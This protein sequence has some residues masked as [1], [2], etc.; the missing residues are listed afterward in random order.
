[1]SY[2]NP[3]I[4]MIVRCPTL[5]YADFLM[6]YF[7]SVAELLGDRD[8]I[9]KVNERQNVIIFA[10]SRVVKFKSAQDESWW[11]GYHNYPIVDGPTLA[12]V[13]D[14]LLI[15]K[16]KNKNAEKQESLL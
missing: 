3:E 1:M 16:G 13:L 12:K 14:K 6:R 2:L 11:I 4:D 8:S 10:S 15:E 9:I 5:E 7:L